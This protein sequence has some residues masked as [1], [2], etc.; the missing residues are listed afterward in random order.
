MPRKIRDLV[1]DLLA[2]GFELR[3]GK[4]SHRNYS[5]PATATLVTISGKDGDYARRYHETAVRQAIDEVNQWRKA[6]DT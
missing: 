6:T 2:V 3:S 5:H 4:G 1:K